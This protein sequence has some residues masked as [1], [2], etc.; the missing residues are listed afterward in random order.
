MVR[1]IDPEALSKGG[2]ASNTPAED[3]RVDITK[4][5]HDLSPPSRPV[6][7][8]NPR[9]RRAQREAAY[10]AQHLSPQPQRPGGLLPRLPGARANRWAHLLSGAPDLDEPAPARSV[11]EPVADTT[12]GEIAALKANMVRLEAE[13]G[14]LK[15]LVDKLCV[16]LGVAG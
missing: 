15:A 8:R 11:A 3:N 10:R 9:P 5:H 16:E 2:K 12:V 6:P 1:S 14:V 13:V 7:A 4:H